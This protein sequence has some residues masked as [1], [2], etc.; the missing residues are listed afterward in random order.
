MIQTPL[1]IHLAVYFESA[2]NATEYHADCQ[3][4]AVRGCN[5]IWNE[6]IVRRNSTN[7]CV[8]GVMSCV[9]KHSRYPRLQHLVKRPASTMA[10]RHLGMTLPCKISLRGERGLAP[11]GKLLALLL[12]LLAYCKHLGSVRSAHYAERFPP[13][14]VFRS[15]IPCHTL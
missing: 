13:R 11:L 7:F 10:Q 14:N 4:L 9:E 15:G 12:S 1:P 6:S 3:Q 2:R 8:A 5:I